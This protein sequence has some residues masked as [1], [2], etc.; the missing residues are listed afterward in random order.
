MSVTVK[1]LKK[2]KKRRGNVQL[3]QT[4]I[5]IMVMIAIG[6]VVFTL[7]NGIGSQIAQSTPSPATNTLFYNLTKVFNNAVD[8]GV[9]LLPSVFLVGFGVIVLGAIMYIWAWFGGG[10]GLGR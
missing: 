3:V 1:I 10:R 7:T 2:L 8:Q 9:A 4:A 6:A 5:A